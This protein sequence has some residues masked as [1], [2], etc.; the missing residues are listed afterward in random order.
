MGED[1]PRT[2]NIRLFQATYS[3]AELN[4][5]HKTMMPSV[6]GISGVVLTDIDEATNRLTVGVLDQRAGAEVEKQLAALGIPP[7]MVNI[8]T[9]ASSHT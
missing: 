7:E 9:T 5:A 6:L 4:E 8:E 3:F 1:A 2:S